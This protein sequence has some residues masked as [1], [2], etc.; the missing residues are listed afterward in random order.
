VEPWRE[1]VSTRSAWRTTI[2]SAMSGMINASGID[3]GA[4][5]RDCSFLLEKL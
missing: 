1:E 4:L 3:L 2:A 5:E